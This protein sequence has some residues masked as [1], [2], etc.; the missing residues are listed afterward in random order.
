[1]GVF[2]SGGAL[3]VGHRHLVGYGG[4]RS[5]RRD[6]MHGSLLGVIQ[7]AVG[8]CRQ[9]PN[10]LG[11]HLLSVISHLVRRGQLSEQCR[12]LACGH[13]HNFYAA[14]GGNLRNV[15]RA[16]RTERDRIT[17]RHDQRRI[18]PGNFNVAWR[19]RSEI[20]SLKALRAIDRQEVPGW[21]RLSRQVARGVNLPESIARVHEPDVAAII[22]HDARPR[23]GRCRRHRHR[24]EHD[25]DDAGRGTSNGRHKTVPLR[26]SCGIVCGEERRCDS[27]RNCAHPRP[28][29]TS[30][31][32]GLLLP[33]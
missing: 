2:K 25:A 14:L 6:T 22:D 12:R 27:R 17:C 10:P 19:Q 24:R 31:R 7:R 1:M 5:V 8:S 32:N 30:T 9:S 11:V 29:R 21:T 20:L 33:A 13:P 15:E 18:D 16:I 28:N 3:A 26:D 4:D 23:M